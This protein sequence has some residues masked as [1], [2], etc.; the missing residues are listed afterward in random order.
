MSWIAPNNQ[1]YN[2]VVGSVNGLGYNPIPTFDWNVLILVCFLL[3][4]PRGNNADKIERRPTGSP[5]VQHHQRHHRYDSH[6][7]HGVRYLLLQLLA[8]RILAYQLVSPRSDYP[9]VKLT[10]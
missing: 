2:N 7:I 3:T 9:Q 1:V 4:P 10:P 6:W 5:C 8:Y